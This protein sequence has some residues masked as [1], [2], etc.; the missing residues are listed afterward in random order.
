MRIGWRALAGAVL[1]LLGAGAGIVFVLARGL[2]DVET[3][4]QYR[5]PLATRI[6][7]RHGRTIGVWFEERRSL[8][9]LRA[10]PP[11]LVQAFLAS[12]DADFFEHGGVD[13]S[14]LLR[15]AWSNLKSGHIAQGGSTITQQLA[16]TLFLGPERTLGRK[17]QDMLLALRIERRLSKEAILEI[18]LNQIYLGAGAYGVSEAAE[19]YFGKRVEDLTLSESALLA[20]LPKAPTALSPFVNPVAAEER[21]RHVLERMIALGRLDPEPGARALAAPPR[22]Q[23]RSESPDFAAAAWFVE[24]VRQALAAELGD[25]AVLRG[26]L[27]VETTLDLA[28]QRSA[29]EAVRAG[30][31]ALAKRTGGGSPP[32]AEGALVSLEVAG[33]DVLAWVGG[34]DFARSRFDR[35]VQARRQPGSAFKTFAY[36]AALAAGFPPDATL[37]DYQVEYTDR[38]SGRSWRPRNHGDTLRGEIPLLEAFGRSLNNATIRLV[39]E[40]GIRRVID[41]ARRAGIRSPLAPEL[42]LALGT[43]EV[44]LLEI[45]NAYGTFASGGRPLAPRFVRRVIDRDGRDLFG[46][47]APAGLAYPPAAGISAV[48]AYLTTHLLREAVQR[49]YGTGHAAAPLGSALAGKTGST[50]EN[51]DA[52]FIG[53]SPEV[54]TGVWVGHDDQMPLGGRETGARAALPIWS[55]Y[56][57]AALR[58]HPPSR[59]RVPQ[60]VVFAGP[61]AFT[62]ER[63]HASAPQPGW[64]PVAEG[65]RERYARFVPPPEPVVLPDG[66]AALP[67]VAAPPPDLPQRT[68]NSRVPT[69]LP[70]AATSTR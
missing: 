12:E 37:Y 43:S 14:A 39:D 13:A 47:K 21:R 58:A 25:E 27:T 16:K 45:T 5:P 17:L 15:A 9:P 28:L 70:S 61:D 10:L 52:W 63:L 55:A 46:G 53:F 19:T 64:V 31:E 40:V 1:V 18:Y 36:G 35:A 6:L 32:R 24:Q 30:L 56:M 41:F 33:G 23:G 68:S 42:G 4:D 62:G 11:H 67:G 57:G 60:R 29:T 26:G 22:V 49:G 59:F 38:R 66:E 54:V 34:Y 51:R 8:A 69:D 20:G 2:P 50:N 48:D 3:L 44:T 7:D 65:R